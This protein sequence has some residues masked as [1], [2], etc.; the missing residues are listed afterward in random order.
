M[1]AARPRFGAAALPNCCHNRNSGT[2]RALRAPVRGKPSRR[3]LSAAALHCPN[4]IN[5]C[6]IPKQNTGGPLAPLAPT[7]LHPRGTAATRKPPPRS[8]AA[9]HPPCSPHSAQA[10]RAAKNVTAARPRFGAAALPNCC[11]NRNSGTARALRAPVRGK[12]SRR[13]LSAAALHCPN[14][15]NRCP[16]PKQNTGG[17]LAP[18]APTALHPRGTAATRKPPPRSRAAAPA[19]CSPHAGGLAGCAVTR[20]AGPFSTRT[21]CAGS[22]VGSVLPAALHA[23]IISPMG[24]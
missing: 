4:R 21:A 19:P 10:R 2:A 8:R 18:L 14:R 22:G 13:R 9:A 11:H 5:R 20:H 15:I 24:P 3:R 17:P 16:I 6:P 12:P 7:A 23:P 1:T